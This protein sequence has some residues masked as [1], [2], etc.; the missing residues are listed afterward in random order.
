MRRKIDRARGFTLLETAVA[1]VLIVTALGTVAGLLLATSGTR[2]Q[3]AVRSD[4]LRAAVAVL[5]Q[6]KL[7]DPSL[8]QANH[9]GTTHHVTGVDGTNGDGS[10]LTVDVD[11]TEPRLVGVTVTASWYRGDSVETLDLRTEIYSGDGQTVP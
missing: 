6:V 9:D 7:T 11:A 2:R 5:E 4:V 1:G 10:A 8:V 3:A